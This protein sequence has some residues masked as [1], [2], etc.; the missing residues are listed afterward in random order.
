MDKYTKAVLA[1]AAFTPICSFAK[2]FEQIRS[3]RCDAVEQQVIDLYSS[4]E[5]LENQAMSP[6]VQAATKE[7]MDARKARDLAADFQG[8]I[9][10]KRERIAEAQKNLDA[11]EAK[12]REV[13]IAEDPKKY[14]ERIDKVLIRYRSMCQ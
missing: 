9:I 11:A 12:F 1:V 4:K 14:L 5:A 13:A 7:F 10:D 2:T 6:V 3:E 8:S